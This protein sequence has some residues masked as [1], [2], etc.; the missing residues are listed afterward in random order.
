[1][2]FLAWGLL[3]AIV[4]GFL[5][6]GFLAKCVRDHQDAQQ[7]RRLS[8]LLSELPVVPSGGWAITFKDKGKLK[9][10]SFPGATES[11]AIQGF[12]RRYKATSI[13]SI[14]KG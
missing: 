13:V 4:F 9:T 3:S 6:L 8:R 11:E 2:I 14:L 12:I 10:E 5:G 1:M 7:Y